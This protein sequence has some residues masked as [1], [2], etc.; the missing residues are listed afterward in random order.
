M[1]WRNKHHSLIQQSQVVQ[2]VVRQNLTKN[3]LKIRKCLQFN[4]I[5][6]FQ[7][8]KSPVTF[9]TKS[10]WARKFKEYPGESISRNFLGGYFPFSEGIII[11]LMEY[12]QRKK[13]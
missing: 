9:S 8:K 1:A 10:E 3:L 6:I 13:S 12:I 5:I 11:I 7:N 4:I 2:F